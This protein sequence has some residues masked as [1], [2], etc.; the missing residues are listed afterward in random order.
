MLID[1]LLFVDRK[2]AGVIEAKKVG[3]TLSG[4]AQP[5]GGR[6]GHYPGL[7]LRPAGAVVW[8]S[9][10]RALAEALALGV[11]GGI[12]SLSFGYVIAELMILAPMES[13]CG[14]INMSSDT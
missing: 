4:V 13:V 8:A 12:Y 5:G 3:T 10:A 11:I 1:Y 2:A 7:H 9:P 14:K 6:V